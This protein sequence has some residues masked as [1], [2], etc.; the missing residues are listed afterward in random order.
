M[1]VS[2][3]LGKRLLYLAMLM[4]LAPL[5]NAQLRI[6][7]TKGVT[8]PIPVAVVPFADTPTTAGAVDIAAVIQ[9]DLDGSGRFRSMDRKALPARPVRASE[10]EAARWRESRNDYVIVGRVVARG[11]AQTA[12]EF[13]LVN[14]LN[15]QVQLTGTET[16]AASQLRNGSHRVAD[17]IYEKI[18]GVRGAFATRIAY[19]SVDGQPPSQ[20]YQLLVA[21]ADGE[22]AR[23]AMQ[24]S[25]PVMSPAWSP[26][27]QS[28]AYV[29]FEGRASAIYV[30][31]VKTGERRQV[32]ARPGVNG[33]PSFSP[34]GKRLALTL[35][36]NTG[37]LDIY[38]LDLASLA[39]TRVTEDAAIDTE[40][41]WSP[42]GQLLYFTSDRGGAP[43]IYSA[44]PKAGAKAR[45]VSFGANYAARPRVSPDG[46]SLAV[47]TQDSGGFR[48]GS[49]ELPSG[50][51]TILSRGTLDESP[52]FAPNGAVLIYA[53]RERGQGMLATVSVDGQVT[54]RLKSDQGDVREPVWGPFAN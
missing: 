33:A 3:R 34:D 30:Q 46:R 24:S 6:D 15:G 50:Q 52:S 2:F 45:R 26:D 4:G 5:A 42:D 8:D 32:S 25:Q 43:Q 37:N 54:Q 44:E 47:V 49:V 35:S 11:T 48:I 18:T 22:N 53:G 27:G 28:L 14:V 29:S 23:V 12:I 21:D 1:Q 19:V 51:V 31:K 16:V 36:G 41:S 39:M 20:R 10:V 40:A 38:V 17:R 9:R 7:I 13:D